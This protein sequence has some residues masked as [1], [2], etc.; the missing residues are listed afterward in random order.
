MQTQKWVIPIIIYL[1]LS[2]CANNSSSENTGSETDEGEYSII[3]TTSS[4]SQSPANEVKNYIDNREE[5]NEIHAVNTDE[6]VLIAITPK[7][8]ERF[9]LA[10]FRK[11][12]EKDL[13]DKIEP[14][15]I[16]LSTDKKIALE[17]KDLEEKLEKKSISKKQLEKEFKRILKL[18][19]EE[20]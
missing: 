18:S 2:G 19:K 1:L 17:L 14:L 16:E 20:T 9:R 10:E 12:L 15:K 3:H 11:E 4:H 13:K 6:Q 8:H 7:H 5:F